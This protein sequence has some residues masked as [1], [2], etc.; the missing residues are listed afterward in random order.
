ME[1]EK[2]IYVIQFCHLFG[3]ICNNLDLFFYTNGIGTEIKRTG[4]FLQFW[5]EK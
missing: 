3:Y 5:V 4:I 1:K 2:H